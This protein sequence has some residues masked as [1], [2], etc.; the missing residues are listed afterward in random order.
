[1]SV[2]IPG[3][4]IASPARE[5]VESL[6]FMTKYQCKVVSNVMCRSFDANTSSAGYP[7]CTSSFAPVIFDLL[8]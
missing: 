8:K 4:M 1:M 7:L 5:N 6:G 3:Y 2:E